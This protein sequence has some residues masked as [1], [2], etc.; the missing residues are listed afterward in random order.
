[1]KVE[2]IETSTVSSSSSSSSKT[3][4]SKSQF[5]ARHFSN[6][7][8]KL[9]RFMSP[10]NHRSPPKKR[11]KHEGCSSITPPDSSRVSI[12]S[13]KTSLHP[14]R[15]VA[16]ETPAK[17]VYYSPRLDPK[18]FLDGPFSHNPATRLRQ[19]LARPG[20]VVSSVFVI[21]TRMLKN[22]F[23]HRSHLAYAM[24]SVPV[25]P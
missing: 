3:H 12:S 20:I 22:S 16:V 14:V 13:P 7:F 10:L 19:M 4:V 2:F 23:L 5:V 21:P 17:A 25:V 18:N 6:L 24:G 1:M 15:Q 11:G 9:D 8:S